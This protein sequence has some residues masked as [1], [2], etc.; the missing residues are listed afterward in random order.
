MAGN[1]S[2]EMVAGVAGGHPAEPDAASKRRSV[3]GIHRIKEHS[4]RARKRREKLT[5]AAQ[6]R[7]STKISHLVK[8][9]EVPNTEAG[10]KKA[11]AMSHSMERAGRLGSR[12]GYRRKT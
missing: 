12:G 8:S 6:K 10:R 1:P 11:A 7:V 9:G 4:S 2:T 3:T 5:G